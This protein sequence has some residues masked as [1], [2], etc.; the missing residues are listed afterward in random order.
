MERQ[1]NGERLKKARIYRGMTVKE[2]AEASGCQ[3]QTLSMYEISKSQPSD[4]GVV[5][6]LADVLNFPVDYFYENENV[7]NKGTVYF[8]SLLTTNKKYRTEQI[9][10]MEFLSQVY[11]LLE[12]Y[13]QFPEVELLP[14]NI[15]YTPESAAKELRRLWG[16]GSEPIKD[17]VTEVEKHGLLVTTFD[18]STSDIDAFSQF[19]NTSSEPTFLIAYSNNKTSAARI[20]FDIAHELGH[21]CLHDWSDDIEEL[22][23]EEFREREKQAHEFAAAFLLPE[24]T[25]KKDAKS[26]SQTIAGYRELKK[27][28]R[29][30][31]AAM[32]RRASQLGVISYAQYQDMIRVMQR[33]GIRKEEP[34][35]DILIT[36]GPALLKTSVMILLHE[37]VFTPQEFMEELAKEYGLSIYPEDVEYL[38]DLPKGTL[39]PEK[40]INFPTLLIKKDK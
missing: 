29:V 30:S 16:L 34:L 12:D 9:I 35:D 4:G 36:A 21:I 39:A 7:D 18:T 5:N 1:F 33:R 25:F 17:I 27:K 15:E 20:H 11:S 31:I 23:K 19:V 26:I 40:T 14:N 28:W 6:K 32:I 10:K 38:L 8:R 3:R 13:I 24:E 2:L 22:T 37:K